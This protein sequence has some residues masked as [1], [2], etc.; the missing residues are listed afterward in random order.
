MD[1]NIVEI[2]SI[3]LVESPQNCEKVLNPIQYH[4]CCALKTDIMEQSRYIANNNSTLKRHNLT[5]LFN[6][7]KIAFKCTK[8]SSRS[9]VIY[10]SDFQIK[11]P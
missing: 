7:I 8:K 2:C 9:A 4:C 11:E 1:I 5:K 10:D 3:M 6:Q